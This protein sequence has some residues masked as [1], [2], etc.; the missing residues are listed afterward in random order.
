MQIDIGVKIDL[1]VLN[2]TKALIQANSG[3]GKSWLLRRIIEETADLIPTIIFDVEGE[4]GTIREKYKNFILIGQEGDIKINLKYAEKL[5]RKLLET[6][7]SAIIDLYELDPLHKRLFVK[8]FLDE[9]ISLPKDL[10]KPT[11]IIID[12]AHLFCPEKGQAESSNAVINLL[13]R[14]RKRGY[15]TILATQ[16]LSKLH[17][18]A[19]AECNNKFIGRAGLDIDRKR[20]A[21]E[22]GMLTKQEV[23]SLRELAAGE[24]YVF[25]PAVSKDVQKIKVN[26]VKTMHPK[27]GM[28][29]I[30][31]SEPSESIKAVLANFRD[32]PEEAEKEKETIESL[33][34]EIKE[35]K[36]NAALQP[37]LKRLKL[38]IQSLTSENKSME[39]EAILL[40]DI[41]EDLLK[42]MHELHNS[43]INRYKEYSIRLQNRKKALEIS[44]NDLPLVTP[45]LR[46]NRPIQKSDI[47]L[48]ELIGHHKEIGGNRIN[49]LVKPIGEPIEKIQ[50]LGKAQK[51]I[52][53]FLALQPLRKFTQIQVGIMTGY[54]PRS[55]SFNTHLSGLS[56][57]GL[58]MRE[59]GMISLNKDYLLNIKNALNDEIDPSLFDKSKWLEK[60]GKGAKLI[61][62]VLLDNPERSFSTAELAKSTGY[63]L[64]GSFNTYLSKLSTLGLIERFSGQIKL[65]SEIKDF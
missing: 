64:S 38:E 1:L 54:A 31:P 11:Q 4:F 49:N 7:Y 6:N 51:L 55:G 27:A 63:Q 8:K 43:G 59:Q 26:S 50:K 42:I 23:L 60:L 17:K 20:A 40:E 61:Y 2:E 46:Q 30:K 47:P 37:E 16:R 58:I 28:R 52:L 45:D 22:L 9:L 56:S 34:K 41:I 14:G 36:I 10:W 25:G 32:I 29:A 5:C 65:S 18:D 57:A 24:F 33:Q 3:G 53:A 12:E 44:S 62:Q 48:D 13:S 19:A 21:E 15:N 39:E 35:L